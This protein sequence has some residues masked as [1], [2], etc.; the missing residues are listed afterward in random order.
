[1]LVNLQMFGYV[2]LATTFDFFMDG[3]VIA[4]P[5]AQ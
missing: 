5:Y 4:N 3:K 2:H 1:M